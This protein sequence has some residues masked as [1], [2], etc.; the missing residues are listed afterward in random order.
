MEE[1]ALLFADTT[2]AAKWCSDLPLDL[3][4]VSRSRVS[5]GLA[6]ESVT[7]ARCLGG[8]RYTRGC[9]YL[10]LDCRGYWARLT[11]TLMNPNG[12]LEVCGP[13]RTFQ[14]SVSI[15]ALASTRSDLDTR[16]VTTALDPSGGHE[17]LV[18]RR[19]ETPSGVSGAPVGAA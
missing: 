2:P 16:L 12:I 6:D 18:S 17:G 7:Y 9:D 4:H 11:L 1:R 5:K 15:F 10:W 19:R 8:V 14:V 3:N 13:T